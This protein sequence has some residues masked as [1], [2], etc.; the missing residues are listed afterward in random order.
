MCCGTRSSRSRHDAA[1]VEGL[2]HVGE[3]R[4][5]RR[6]N[7]EREPVALLAHEHELVVDD[8]VRRDRAARADHRV[9]ARRHPLL[10]DDAIRTGRGPAALEPREALRRRRLRTRDLRGGERE[11]Q[12]REPKSRARQTSA[13]SALRSRCAQGH[14][15][16]SVRCCALRSAH[17]MKGRS[18]EPMSTPHCESSVVTWPR[19]CAWWLKRCVIRSQRGLVRWTPSTLLV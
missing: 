15:A 3:G 2:R 9:P 1:V 8:R 10:L 19:W 12:D 18:V 17:V 6:P 16:Q 14:R 4:T 11:R 5:S 7:L 13:E